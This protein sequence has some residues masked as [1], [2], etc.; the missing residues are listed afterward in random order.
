M[1][2]YLKISI[3]HIK[4]ENRKKI[5][6][7]KD[8]LFPDVSGISLYGTPYKYGTFITISICEYIG[9]RDLYEQGYD[10]LIP[11]V[12]YCNNRNVNLIRFDSLGHENF[13]FQI[14]DQ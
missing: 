9:L 2:S 10:D 3:R 14:Y 5:L 1:E 12:R 11:I 8:D 13:D 6:E 7:T 4:P